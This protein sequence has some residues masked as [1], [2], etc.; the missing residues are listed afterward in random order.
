MYGTTDSN[1]K[2]TI[3]V[4]LPFNLDKKDKHNKPMVEF[5]RG[6]LLAIDSMRNTGRSEERRVGKECPT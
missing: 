1:N 4:A 2:V 6:F 3:A 5:Y